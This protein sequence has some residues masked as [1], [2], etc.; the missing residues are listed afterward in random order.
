MSSE[1]DLT[2]RARIRDAAIA[3]F[4]ERGIAGATI[5]DIAQAAGVSSGLLRHHFGSKEG[6]RDA[7]DEWAMGQIAQM[8]MRFTETQAIGALSPETLV[9]QQYLVRSLM[10]GSTRGSAMFGQAVSHGERW[11][12]AS[13]L[14]TEDPQAFAA[15]LAAMKMGMFLMRDQ[16]SAVLGENAMEPHGYLRMIRASLE[17]FSQPLL[18]PDQADRAYKELDRLVVPLTGEKGTWQMPSMPKD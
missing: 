3:L 15:V 13:G 6:L 12:V 16:L 11:V 14:S 17:I 10:D 5:R 18:T 9:F 2:A 4:T 1:S 8:Q 7:C